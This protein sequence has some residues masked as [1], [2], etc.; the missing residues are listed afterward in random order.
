MG[1]IYTP[2]SPTERSSRQKLNR[3]IVKLTDVIS[4]MDLTDIYRTF[5]PNTEEYIFSSAPLGIFFKI[6]HI[7]FVTYSVT[8]QVTTGTR[9]LK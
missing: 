7:Y 8:K 2:L 4:Q 1:D 3:E 6:D 5:H 9:K